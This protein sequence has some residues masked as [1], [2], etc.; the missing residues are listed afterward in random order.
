MQLP[1][2]AVVAPPSEGVLAE[3]KESVCTFSAGLTGFP[4]SSGLIK[5]PSE[6]EALRAAAH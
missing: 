6:R 2:H 3:S 5:H 4:G 1:I